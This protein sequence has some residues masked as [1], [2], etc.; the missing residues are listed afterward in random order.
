[1][2]FEFKKAAPDGKLIFKQ[3]RKIPQSV[4]VEYTTPYMPGEPK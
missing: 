3:S 2:D 1:M 4:Y